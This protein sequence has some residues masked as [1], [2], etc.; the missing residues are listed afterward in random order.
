MFRGNSGVLGE[1]EGGGGEGGARVLRGC[2][3][4]GQRVL[5]LSG[6]FI[7]GLAYCGS[8]L[9]ELAQLFKVAHLVQ[10]FRWVET[11]M[12][13]VFLMGWAWHMR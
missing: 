5:Y 10:G 8:N 4:V 9:N 13:V 12:F 11:K 1:G 7:F 2:K 3:C 6:A